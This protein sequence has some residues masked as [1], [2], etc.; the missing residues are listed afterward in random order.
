MASDRR[1][2]LE[3]ID[4]TVRREAHNLVSWPQMTWQQLYNRLQWEE[5]AAEL[6]QAQAEG[7]AERDPA[8]WAHVKAPY[9]ESSALVR[10]LSGH[11]FW[12]MD[13]AVSPSGDVLA[14]ASNAE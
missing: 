7:R 4:R 9:P 5:G 8:P 14:S 6:L 11:D 1:A 3:S 12:V 2:V 13:V 10:T